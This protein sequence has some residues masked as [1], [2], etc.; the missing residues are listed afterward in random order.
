MLALSSYTVGTNVPAHAEELPL[1]E[2]IGRDH[3]RRAEME[4]FVAACF[5]AQ[6]GAQ[7]RQFLPTLLVLRDER[8]TLEGVAGCAPAGEYRLFL[9]QYLDTPIEEAIAARTGCRLPRSAIVEVGNLATASPGGARRLI[10]AV[11]THLHGRGHRWVVFTATR[12]LQNAFRRLGLRPQALAPAD[13]ARLGP[14]AEAW[15][16]YYA[17]GP[18]VVCGPIAL[19]YHRLHNDIAE[20]AHANPPPAAG[21]GA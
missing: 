16:T 14:D 9:E 10:R 20:Q 3:P 15:G 17:Q 1:L 13:P 18:H 19:G 4:A 12:M 2:E 11:T 8:G 21:E 6:Y 7:L 5:L